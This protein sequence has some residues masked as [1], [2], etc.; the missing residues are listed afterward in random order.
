MGSAYAAA[1]A[2]LNSLTASLA[3]EVASDGVV[4]IALSPT[5][6]TDMGRQ[7]YEND[8][9]PEARREFLR[10]YISSDPKD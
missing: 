10:A 3:S 9:L 7:L 8:V 1:K 4:V 6:H 2:G 5:A